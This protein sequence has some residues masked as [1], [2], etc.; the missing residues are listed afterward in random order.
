[1]I[2]AWM[3]RTQLLLGDEKL[4]K[5]INSNV[6][7]LGLGGVGGMC[8]EMIAR[9]GVGKMT[10]VDADT[11]EASNRNRQLPAL[12][13]TE[14][15]L[16]AEV[17]AERLLDIN[18]KLQLTILNEYLREQRTLDVLDEGNFDY[19]CDCIDTLTPKVYFIKSCM[20]R[21]IPVVSSMG[22]GGKVDP[23]RIE[24]CDISETRDDL[25][26]RYVRKYLYRRYSIKTG[27]TVVYSPERVDKSKIIL[28]DDITKKKSTIGTISY[29]PAVFGCTVASVAIRGLMNLKIKN[30]DKLSSLE[31]L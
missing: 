19:A 5:I 13:S 17:L 15:K 3:G 1:M 2:D 6:I 9:A 10:L 11:I 27:L 20:E 25:L 30:H 21:N 23:S 8:A 12:V 28:N 22:A 7:I 14:N 31:S 26:A 18:P 24:V 29:M 4:K 16:K